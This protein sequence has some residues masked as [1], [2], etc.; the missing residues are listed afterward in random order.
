MDSQMIFSKPLYVLSVLALLL[1]PT[2]SYAEDALIFSA[3]PRETPEKGVKT[4]GEIAAFLTKVI[5][6]KVIYKH[7]RNW[8]AYSADMRKGKYDIVFDGPHFVSWRVKAQDHTPLVKIPGDFTFVI[9]T[10]KDNDKIQTVSD[11]VSK[12]ICGH[13][14]PNQGTLRIYNQFENPMRLPVLNQVKGWR[15]IYKAM[16]NKECDGA[17][18]PSKIY[19]KLDK[20]GLQ[21]RVL[22]RTKATPGQ[23]ITASKKFNVKMVT[24]M[25]EALLSEEGKLATAALRKRFASPKLTEATSNEYDTVYKILRDT[26]GFNVAGK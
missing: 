14:P 15:N 12:K 6:K 2:L 21:T 18:V 7:S 11:L 3:P 13:A 17:I 19:N 9:L 16:I 10:Q 4:Y 25:R 1:T 22:L 5:G 23:A 26:Y 20:E 24:K 8:M